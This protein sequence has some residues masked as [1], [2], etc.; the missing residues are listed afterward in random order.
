MDRTQSFL[1]IDRLGDAVSKA[2]S[3]PLM[4][5]QSAFDFAISVP[6]G[7]GPAGARRDELTRPA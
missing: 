6:E 2:D 4:S 1:A 3:C 7:H 5:G